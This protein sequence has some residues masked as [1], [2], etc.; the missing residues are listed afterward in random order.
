ARRVVKAR[1][2]NIEEPVDL[3]EVEAAGSQQ[4]RRLFRESEA[5]LDDLEAGEVVLATRKVGAGLLGLPGDGAWAR[6]PVGVVAGQG[7][8]PLAGG[9]VEH[10]GVVGAVA[11]R[12]LDAGVLVGAV[13]DGGDR[14]PQRVLRE[15]RVV[16]VAGDRE[17][18]R[19]QAVLETLEG[20]AG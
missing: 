6:G 7:D 18:R 11:T 14:R 2:R 20:E 1:V 13:L 3:Y 9:Q 5:A 19:R 8:G 17:C 16:G 10:D 4:R 12:A 15:R